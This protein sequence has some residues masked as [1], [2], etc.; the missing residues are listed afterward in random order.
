MNHDIDR[1]QVGYA[2]E[3]ESY[4]PSQGGSIFNEDEHGNLV[5]GLMEP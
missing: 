1:T 2:Q 4:G 3:A 5:A